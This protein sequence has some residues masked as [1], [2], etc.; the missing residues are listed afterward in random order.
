M[1]EIIR[2]K[3][4][5]YFKSSVPDKTKI[6]DSVV[7]V[8]SMNR[9]AVIKAFAR[10]RKR[11]KWSLP[12]TRG[13]PKLYTADTEAA[14][15][16]IWEQYDYPSAE[17]LVLEIT[18]AIRIFKRDGMWDYCDSTTHQLV[19]MSLGAMKIRCI[20]MAKK[21]GLLRGIST[22]KSGELLRSVPV[23][24][25]SW[26]NK[27]TGYGQVDTVVHSGPKLMGTMA[28]T[29]NY[30]DVATYWQEPI[31]QLN[32]SEA[33]TYD[34]LQTIKNRLPFPMTG[35]HPD[36]GSEFINQVGITWC[37]KN[38][39]DLSRSRPYKK[40]DNRYVEQR[41]RVVVRKYVGYERYDCHEAVI[42][43]NELYDV[44][45]LYLN[46]FQPTY[47]LI[48]KEKRVLK[49]DGTQAAK[50]Y[51]RIY[52]KIRTPYQRVL[53]QQDVETRVK[54]KLTKQYE[55]LNPKVLRDTIKSLTIKLHKAQKDQGYH[56]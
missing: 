4:Q 41:N 25:G 49:V 42:V 10:E 6:I 30:T 43:M 3:K 47:K 9:K 18:E 38:S 32:K 15:A 53:D 40:N 23:F 28:Y 17:R 34:S 14:L 21:R 44:L 29:V 46:F 22:T 55:S 35:L 8:T 27:G 7:Q 36:S 12:E 56:F 5:A 33:A 13:R 52:D 1:R 11:R 24:F 48:R 39:V 2:D 54:Q 16:F 26:S 50:P 19:K 51:K 45:R 20:A 37:E 31:A